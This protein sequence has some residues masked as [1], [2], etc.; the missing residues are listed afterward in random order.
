MVKSRRDKLVAYYRVSTDKQADS[1]LG[2]EAQ[3]AAVGAFAERTGATIIGTYQETES[4]RN[5]RRPELQR[6][7]DHAR[8]ARATLVVKT[9]DRLTRNLRFLTE[10]MDAGVDFIAVDQPDANRLTLHILAVVAEDETRRISERT[11]AALA[12]ARARGVKLGGR[13]PGHERM[14]LQS[15]L[16]A[17]TAG[18]L[19]NRSRTDSYYQALAPRVQELRLSGMTQ[20]A[21]AERF[22]SEGLTTQSGGPW[23]QV[24]V[25]RVLRR[26]AH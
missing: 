25:L 10:M 20:A 1:G 4:G 6:A 3:Q 18:A 7:L 14:S 22:N 24:A 12:A 9:L 23:T 19:V 13:R 11:K 8:A 16:R 26:F 17:A 15:R 2:L 21:I 5:N